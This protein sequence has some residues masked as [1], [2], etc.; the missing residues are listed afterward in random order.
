M[1]ERGS[2]GV[3]YWIEREEGAPR[4]LRLDHLAG[5]IVDPERSSD[6]RSRI[7]S[8]VAWGLWY[9]SKGGEE[10]EEKLEGRA[11]EM[12]NC[13]TVEEGVLSYD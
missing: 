11:E 10:G 4:D 3:G 5:M 8:D 12:S 7:H 9:D 13:M 2:L 6:V 1:L